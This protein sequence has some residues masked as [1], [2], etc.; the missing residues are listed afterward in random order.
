MDC[1]FSSDERGQVWIHGVPAE[2]YNK[3]LPITT[4]QHTDDVTKTNIAHINISNVRIT[5]FSPIVKEAN[6]EVA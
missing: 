6:N 2:E 4:D 1:T 5:L 3:L